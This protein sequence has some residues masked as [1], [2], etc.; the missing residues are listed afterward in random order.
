MKTW[1]SIIVVLMIAGLLP[2]GL[3]ALARSRPSAAPPVH[4]IQDMY[5]QPKFRSQRENAMFADGRAMRP[6][7]ANVEATTDLLV[8]E[9]LTPKDAAED[10][11]IREGTETLADGKTGF[12]VRIPVPVTQVLME[13]GRERFDIYCAACHGYG[14]YGDG[15]VSRRAAEMQAAGSA[16]AAAWVAPTNYHGDDV[17]NRPVGHIYNTITNGIR[18]MPAYGKQVPVADRW[19]IVAYVKALQR[20]QNAKE[21]DVPENQQGKF[22]K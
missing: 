3:I 4:P 18:N 11:R 8:S 9:N 21:E 15:M 5:R 16:D 6:L 2:F 14:G 12:V 13:R 7:V 1:I 10:Q 20:S 17:R 19:A 22:Q